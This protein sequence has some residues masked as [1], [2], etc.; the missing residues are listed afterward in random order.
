M[1]TALH[2][3][4]PRERA[5]GCFQDFKK[6]LN[7]VEATQEAH[8]CINCFDA[9]CTHACPTTIDIPKFIRR[10]AA[11]Q[12]AAAGKTIL[13]ANIFG[14]SCAVACPVEVLCEGACVYHALDKKPISIGKLQRFALET[15]GSE[16]R[17]FFSPGDLAQ[18]GPT[19]QPTPKPVALIGAGPASLACAHELRRL[20]Y[21][22]TVFEKAPLP[23]GLNTS[24]IA[25][26]K[27]RAET[28]VNEIRDIVEP[29]GIEIRYGRTLGNNL[30]W[31]ELLNQNSYS[32]VFLGL[33]LGPDTELNVEGHEHA[34]ILGAVAFVHALKTRPLKELESTLGSRETALVVGGGNT[35][36]DACRELKGFGFA[37]VVL[38][39]R[40]G[41]N[42]MSGYLHEAKAAAVEGVEFEY[43]T[44]PRTFSVQNGSDRVHATLAKTEV[45]DGRVVLTDQNRATLAC[46]LV[47]LAI[48]QSGLERT[49]N[50]PGLVWKDGNL[51]VDPATGQTSLPRVFAGGDLVNG[52]KEVVNAVAEGKRAA[53]G[54]DQMLRGVVQRG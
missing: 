42:S 51:V 32:A 2:V 34:K 3:D 44:V 28:S 54:I 8:R 15:S 20:G 40:R 50:Y 14:H 39:Y 46:D 26:Y 43:H 12:P 35:A 52:G 36:L 11:G 30:K 38:S 5:E 47:L 22:T 24:G 53:H 21:A 27:M 49:L 6:A 13:E 10:I 33:G 4:L 48:G 18:A 1:N 31:D 45:R 37:R 17:D 29:M 23:G 16:R 41:K 7:A 25:P 9:P 19:I